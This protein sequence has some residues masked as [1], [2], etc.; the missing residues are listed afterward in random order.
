MHLL[1]KI[2]TRQV[3]ERILTSRTITRIDQQIL[4]ACQT[5]SLE[6]QN[7]VNQVF[8]RLQRGLL[9]VVE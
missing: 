4:L 7:L 9:K 8:D 1:P 2:S 6:E 5:L 3:V